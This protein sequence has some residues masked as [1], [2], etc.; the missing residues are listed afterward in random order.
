MIK[1]TVVIRKNS[2]TWH[3]KTKRKLEQKHAARSVNAAGFISPVFVV[4]A[5]T[6]FSG[7][8]YI[9]S[10]NQTAVKG[11]AIRSAEKEVM[12][13]RKDN[14]SLKIKEAE[15]KSLYRIEDSS[16][17]L[18]MVDATNVKYLEESPTVTY[19]GAQDKHKN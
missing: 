4:L 18:N 16:K 17:N 19:S 9:Y 7:L 11:L 2:C 8:F 6:A 10:V 1:R 15:L 12:Q 13:Q 14:E 3:P 5:C